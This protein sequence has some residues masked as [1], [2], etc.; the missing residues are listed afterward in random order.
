[1]SVKISADDTTL[2]QTKRKVFQYPVAEIGSLADN[3]L[4]STAQPFPE[5]KAY[6]QYTAL[7]KRESGSKSTWTLKPH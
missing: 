2:W 4:L 6:Q 3:V 7:K 5:A 1:M